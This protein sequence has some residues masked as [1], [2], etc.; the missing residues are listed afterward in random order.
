MFELRR[1][2]FRPSAVSSSC[3]YCRRRTLLACTSHRIMGNGC[4]I[5]DKV[6]EYHSSAIHK[7][8]TAFSQQR[9]RHHAK[10]PVEALKGLS[11]EE[12]R[13]LKE[14]RRQERQERQE[15]LQKRLLK[16]R[17]VGSGSP[18]LAT[19]TCSSGSASSTTSSER[20]SPTETLLAQ[21]MR[22][23]PIGNLTVQGQSLRVCWRCGGWHTV[24]R[25]H[26]YTMPK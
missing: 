19:S 2:V 3:M 5:Y 9:A 17:A 23:V 18:A 6:S 7:A 15:T 24:V 14:S 22:I 16:S 1:K 25:V 26:A 11:K 12:R 10:V 13:A 20:Q 4:R 21:V 8:K